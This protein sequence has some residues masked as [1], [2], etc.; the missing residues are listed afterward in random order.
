MIAAPA[1]AEAP[2]F[3]RFDQA[4]DGAFS[5][6]HRV[7]APKPGWRC[8]QQ[9]SARGGCLKRAGGDGAPSDSCRPLQPLLSWAQ[10]PSTLER[11]LPKIPTATFCL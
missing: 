7:R 2:R 8:Q 3:R 9:D 10:S 5:V 4:R 6:A 1:H 11:V